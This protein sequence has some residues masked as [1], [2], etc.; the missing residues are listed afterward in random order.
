MYT[1]CLRSNLG[2][3]W[4]DLSVHDPVRLFHRFHLILGSDRVIFRLSK[5]RLQLKFLSRF[6]ADEVL[7][8]SQ[9][10]LQRRSLFG[11]V[12]RLSFSLLTLTQSR[13]ELSL[14]TRLEV[15]RNKMN[16]FWTACLLFCIWI[17]F[18]NFFTVYQQDHFKS[19]RKHFVF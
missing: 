7:S 2:R 18:T 19:P 13:F 1:R 5:T 4:N 12:V 14:A 8:L 11:E 3:K 16:L 17:K 15:L 10:L 9:L 6:F